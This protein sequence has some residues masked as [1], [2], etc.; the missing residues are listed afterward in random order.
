VEKGLAS[1]RSF[2][3]ATTLL[4]LILFCI[5]CSQSVVAQSGFLTFPLANQSQL[6]HGWY[7]QGKDYHGAI[8][9]K[10]PVD[11]EVLAAADGWTIASC[12]PSPKLGVD[13]YGN[14]V[15]I[16]H[17]N[18]YSTLYAHLNS[19]SSNIPQILPCEGRH[20]IKGGDVVFNGSTFRRT[21][22][23]RGTVIGK[24][25]K[26][27]TTYFHLHFEVSKNSTGSY[28][29][30][31]SK[32][33]RID[34]YVIYSVAKDYPPTA[35]C[36]SSL[37]S[38]FL[39]TSCPPSKPAVIGSCA[40]PPSGLVSWWQ[41]EGN[42]TDIISGNNGT[43]QNGALFAM[44]E[45]G[46]AFSFNG[47]SQYVTI[48]DSPSLHQSQEITIEA[49]VR[50][51][52]MPTGTWMS[53]I[54]KD[55]PDSG[56]YHLVVYKDGSVGWQVLPSSS[57]QEVNSGTDRISPGVFSHIAGT[58]NASTGAF[59]V[60]VNGHPTCTQ[61]SGP[62][63]I[64]SNAVKIG[65]DLYNNLFFKGEIDEVSIYNRALS[66]SEIQAIFNAGTKGKCKP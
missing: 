27:G 58:Y 21:F 28:D 2:L 31:V 38:N 55:N 62:M 1:S 65:G 60:Y 44:G 33:N 5:L 37:P 40:P 17:G 9:I 18:G 51:A 8:D 57:W 20:S 11:T 19:I 12:Q 3:N 6:F 7:Y 35:A 52:E 4:I 34:P 15:L 13:G 39:W 10:A 47:N 54:T 64:T 29:T 49:W 61:L 16:D 56:P 25:G 14:F 30:H 59:C 53:V 23:S 63:R 26:T 24:V 66:A 43:L 41:G 36:P 32:N 45:V 50:P 42:A 22:V 48:P 46:Q